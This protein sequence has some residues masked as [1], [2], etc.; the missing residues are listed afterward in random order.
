[1]VIILVRIRVRGSLCRSALN[2]PILLGQELC[3]VRDEQITIAN[4]SSVWMSAFV[5]IK[6]IIVLRILKRCCPF[7]TIEDSNINQCS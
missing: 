3:I 7:R 1:M 2:A 4:S 5:V 6:L